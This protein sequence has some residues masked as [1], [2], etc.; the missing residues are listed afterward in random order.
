ME[1]TIVGVSMEMLSF[2]MKTSNYLN[3]TPRGHREPGNTKVIGHGVEAK[4]I[5]GNSKVRG[6]GVEANKSFAPRQVKLTF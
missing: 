3:S 1:T 6:P 5:H 2:T 4:A